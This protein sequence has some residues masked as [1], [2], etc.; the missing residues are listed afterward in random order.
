MDKI[1]FKSNVFW[2][3]FFDGCFSEVLKDEQTSANIRKIGR[4]VMTKSLRDYSL[5]GKG[6]QNAVETGLTSAKYYSSSI[7]RK[8]LKTFI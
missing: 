5:L 2:N 8:E 1:L 4:H 3:V 7:S 6:S